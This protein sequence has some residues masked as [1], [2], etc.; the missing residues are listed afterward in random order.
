[1]LH[2][3]YYFDLLQILGTGFDYIFL[4]AIDTYRSIL[5]AWNP[6]CW[7]ASNPH[8]GT[9]SASV[10]LTLA[11]GGPD[12]WLTSICGPTTDSDKLLF[13]NELCA[14][15]NNR[16]GLWLLCSDF[17]MIYMPMD[18]SNDR[19]DLGAWTSSGAF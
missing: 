1:V 19:L 6:S 4:P 9:Y 12:W 17:N 16:D 10:K 7:M 2:I 13:L 5:V 15:W 8:L 18:K 3:I 14:L 11:T